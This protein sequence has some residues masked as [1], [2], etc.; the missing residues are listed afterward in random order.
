MGK[1]TQVAVR[2]EALRIRSRAVRESW[3]AQWRPVVVPTVALAVLGTVVSCGF[4]HPFDVAE[5][6]VYAHA[7]LRAPLFH[8]LPLEYPAPALIVFL[9]P[10]LLHFS[11]PWAFALVA[12][13]VLVVLVTS[14]E[15]SGM[16]G[17][18]IEAARRLIVYLAVGAVILVTGRYDIFAVAAAFWSVRAARQQRWS[19]AWTW[20]SI[21]FV[22]K[23][24]PAVFWPALLIAEWRARGR[25]PVRRLAWMAG[26]LVVVAGLPALF[27][28]EATLNALHYYLRRPTETGSIPAGLSFLVDWHGSHLVN[29]FHSINIEN[30]VVAPI[31]VVVEGAAVVGCLWVWWAQ[32]RDRIPFEAACLATLTLAV[33]GSKVLSAQYV[34]WLMPLWALYAFRSRWLLAALTNI[35]VFPYAVSRQGFG[36]V[37]THAFEGSLCLIFLA[38]DLLIAWGTWAWLRS[39]MVDRPSVPAVVAPAARAP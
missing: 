6:D 15:S 34:I 12:G 30:A 21:G 36:L 26:S 20:S 9:A 37:P 39:V 33:L 1:A 14:Y 3:R 8:R 38:R 5:Y 4:L 10:V 32:R 31:S 7:A 28:H 25:L 29:T 27:N 16:A 23:L 35:A 18:D 13:I 22:I 19:A 2:A 17:M 11:Y 24:F